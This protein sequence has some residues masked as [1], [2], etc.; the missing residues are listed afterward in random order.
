V[1][2]TIAVVLSAS[3]KFRLREMGL[4]FL[5]AKGTWRAILFVALP[6]LA[7]QAVLLATLF[8]DT[9]LPGRETILFQATMPGLAEELS[10]RGVILALLDRAFMGYISLGGG[11]LGYGAVVVTLF[12]GLLHGITIGGDLQLHTSLFSGIYVALVGVVLVWLRQRTGSIAVPVI[13]HN[14]INVVPNVVLK[15]I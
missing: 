5:Q 8:G 14:A 15:A 6:L 1:V 11:K 12:F 13:F 2:A 7:L 3:G 10:F 9:T 4:S